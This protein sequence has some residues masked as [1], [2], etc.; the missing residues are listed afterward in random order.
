M[1]DQ[2]KTA[3]RQFTRDKDLKDTA[4]ELVKVKK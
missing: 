1:G 4:A 2:G 3:I